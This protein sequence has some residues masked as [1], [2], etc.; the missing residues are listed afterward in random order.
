MQENV[1]MS[2]EEEG[3]V[4]KTSMRSVLL[5]KVIRRSNIF[6]SSIR[7]VTAVFVLTGFAV[8]SDPYSL[9]W[10]P[11]ERWRGF[12]LGALFQWT[13]QREKAP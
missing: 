6:R 7:F 12:N 1:H 9:E 2:C 3:S 5:H 4:S 13:P 8:Q 11:E 10:R